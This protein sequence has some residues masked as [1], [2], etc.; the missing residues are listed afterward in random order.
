MLSQRHGIIVERLDLDNDYNY[1]IQDFQ[2]KYHN[3][4][5]VVSLSA[6]SNVT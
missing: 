5:K 6:A 1:N 3:R 2:K 4:V